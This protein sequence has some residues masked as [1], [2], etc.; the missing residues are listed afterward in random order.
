MKYS[1]PGNVFVGIVCM[2]VMS[3]SNSELSTAPESQVAVNNERLE[4]QDS[5]ESFQAPVSENL[6]TYFGDYNI[7]RFTGIAW[8]IFIFN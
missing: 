6:T 4:D 8:T 5:M 7:D 2:M 1:A 3:C